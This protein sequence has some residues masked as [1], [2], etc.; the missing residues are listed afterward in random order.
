MPRPVEEIDKLRPWYEEFGPLQDEFYKVI[1]RKE[2]IGCACKS[3]EQLRLWFTPE[4]YVKLLTFD[5]RVVLV[6]NC[7]IIAESDTQCVFTRKEPLR[8]ASTVIPLY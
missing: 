8:N 3:V 5:Y 1:S 6:D 2:H 4:E 7:T